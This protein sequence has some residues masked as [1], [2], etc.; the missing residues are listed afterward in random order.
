MVEHFL[1]FL[2]LV[3][4]LT[5]LTVQAIKKIL[6]EKKIKY[7]ANILAIGISIIL[8]IAVSFCYAIYF[9]IDINSH[10]IIFV[11]S[12]CYLSFLTSTLGYDKIIQT[13]KQ[14]GGD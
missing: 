8:S 6:D 7:S 4:L 11:I 13:I 3:S 12:L 14:I 2:L 5:N 9:Y 10:F 1:K